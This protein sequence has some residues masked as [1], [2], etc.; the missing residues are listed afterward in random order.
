MNL[1][2]RTQRRERFVDKVRLGNL[3]GIPDE[4]M[5]DYIIDGFY[6]TTLQNQARI[7]NF[8][9]LETLLTTMNNVTDR[10][11][12]FR[13]RVSQQSQPRSAGPSYSASKCF[14]CNEHGH[15]A[16]RCPTQKREFLEVV[17]SVARHSTR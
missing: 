15:V 4:E 17:L 10:G 1:G 13:P 6:D 2:H 16:N 3:A 8:Q 11:T 5:I 12:S 14:N 9:S 7:A